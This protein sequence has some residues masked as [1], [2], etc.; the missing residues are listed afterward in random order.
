MSGSEGKA[1]LELRGARPHDDDINP[2]AAAVTLT[3]QPGELALVRPDDAGVARALAELCAGLPKLDAGEVRFMG[4]DWAALTRP[5]AEN[6]R[7]RIGLAPGEGGWLP[8]LSMPENLI[9]A[10]RHHGADDTDALMREADALC[11]HFGLDGLPRTTPHEMPPRDLTRAAAA[12]A[13]MGRPA[14]FLLHDP[15][16]GAAADELVGPLRALL[17]PALAA[18]AAAVWQS[19]SPL[20]WEDAEVR[21][22]QRLRLGL[23]GLAPA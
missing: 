1:V 2:I 16:D 19:C 11:R 9:L 18:G 10:R 7:G 20:L 12:R 17:G 8:H 22:A 23:H 14:L 15:P 4:E 6:L 3:V 13:F 21:P 5:Q